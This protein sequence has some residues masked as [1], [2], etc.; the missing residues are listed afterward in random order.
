MGAVQPSCPHCRP[1]CVTPSTSTHRARVCCALPLAATYTLATR[2][3]QRGHEASRR[4]HTNPQPPPTPRHTCRV[5]TGTPLAPVPLQSSL[6]SYI[7]HTDTIM[8]SPADQQSH[9]TATLRH[10][11]PPTITST[12]PPQLA[13]LHPL[14]PNADTAASHYRTRHHVTSIAYIPVIAETPSPRPNAVTPPQ[15]HRPPNHKLELPPHTHPPTPLHF[16]RLHSAIHT[17]HARR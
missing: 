15:Q 6:V 4:H 12:S 13:R 3:A 10:R 9:V 8:R 1:H 17:S 11:T 2:P 14:P 7:T 16:L 5:L